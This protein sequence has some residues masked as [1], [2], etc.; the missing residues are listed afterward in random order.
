MRSAGQG[1]AAP[2][3]IVIPLYN[4]A[5]EIKKTLGRV[6]AQTLLPAKLVVV[7]DGSRDGSADAAEQFLAAANPGFEWQVIRAPHR[8]AATARNTGFEQVAHLPHVAFLDSDD[9][10]PPDFLARTFAMLEAHP[11]AVAL[12]TDREIDGAD[13]KHIRLDLGGMAAD[14]ELWMNRHDAGIA[15]CTVLC[16]PAVQNVGGW[17]D[18]LEAGE[19]FLLFTAI[20][21]QGDWLHAGGAPVLFNRRM[22]GSGGQQVNLSR[23]QPRKHWVWAEQAEQ[24]MQAAGDDDRDRARSLREAV[25]GRWVSPGNHLMRTRFFGLAR[26]AYRRALALNPASPGV[27]ARAAACALL[28]PLGKDDR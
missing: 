13:R 10:W 16:C 18:G 12:S 9:H 6:L 24:L 4:R 14:P 20:A 26:Y 7:D 2:I 8:H 25:A 17:A 15:S 22:S 28:A 19:D 23:S 21:R 27:K 11:A 1:V 5:Q 3:G